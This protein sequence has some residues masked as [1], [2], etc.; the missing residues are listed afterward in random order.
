[1]SEGRDQ[2]S[3]LPLLSLGR[4]SVRSRSHL[5]PPVGTPDQK[6]ATPINIRGRSIR[7]GQFGEDT[8]PKEGGV[9]Q[10]FARHPI[11]GPK[12][13]LFPPQWGVNE[14]HPGSIRIDDDREQRAR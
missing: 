4:S 3:T 12:S 8:H 10:P 6:T 9:V 7:C 13:T 2:R 11:P 1:M 14:I 5:K